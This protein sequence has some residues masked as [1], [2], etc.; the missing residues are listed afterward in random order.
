MKFRTKKR[1]NFFDCDP[2]GI[3]FFG[4]AFS[5]MHSA[6]EE[7]ITSLGIKDYWN[8]DDFFVPITEASTKYNTPVK[9]GQDIII[10]VWISQ[11]RERSFE[12][13]YICRSE[14]KVEFFSSRTVHIFTNRN[15]EKIS[16]PNE[17]ET[18]LKKY[19]ETP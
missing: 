10:D 8:S 14:N 18:K 4:K 3:M 1:I 6:Y 12:L 7:M 17:I 2:A 9:A 13:Q 11:L 5:L 15:F 19:S 16:I